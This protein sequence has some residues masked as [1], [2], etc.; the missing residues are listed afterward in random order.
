MKNNKG[1][2]LIELLAVIIVLGVLM[3]V[4]IPSVTTYINNSR[5]N[6]YVT[7]AKKLVGGGVIFANS[8]KF[9]LYDTDTTYYIPASCIATE[10]GGDASPYDKWKQKYIIVTY[11]GDNY[12][13]Y[14]AS[15][16]N[17]NMGIPLTYNDNIDISCIKPNIKSI[18][19]N[20]GIGDRTKIMLF[21]ETTDCQGGT[22]T[23]A[24]SSLPERVDCDYKVQED[25][26]IDQTTTTDGLT[27][28]YKNFSINFSKLDGP[29]CNDSGGTVTCYSAT[30]RIKNKSEDE[31]IKSYEAS[32]TIPSG[33]RINTQYDVNAANI[34]ISGT[35]LK[36]IGNPNNYTYR[37]LKPGDEDIYS[38]NFSYNHET[39]FSLSNGQI[40]YDVLNSD[41]QGGESSGDP[42]HIS[43]SIQKLKV[44]LDRTN[45]YDSG[46]YHQAQYNLKI[47]NLTNESIS[48]WSVVF[49][50]PDEIVDFRVYSPLKL[51]KTNKRYVLTS[52]AN[53][54]IYTIGPK[55]SIGPYQVQFAMTDT[56]A[57]PTIS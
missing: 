1:F 21:D 42:E 38:F 16:D 20:V 24:T 34:S 55:A 8:G 22:V 44:E 23:Q 35:T 30:I 47:T 46:G 33:A 54:S 3:L 28:V 5:K 19:T 52:E 36:I 12:D 45:L 31:T 9:D 37:Y 14:W 17:S 6:A 57:I 10:T 27:W 13:Y 15:T 2:T 26:P 7:T 41:H 40:K 32:F 4:A 56:N 18:S 48:N 51:T 50:M 53:Q 25:V 49:D 43:T 11:S 39:S 29:D